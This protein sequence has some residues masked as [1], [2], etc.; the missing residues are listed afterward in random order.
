MIVCVA[1][2]ALVCGQEKTGFEVPS[3]VV[4]ILTVPDS[5]CPLRLTGPFSVIGYPSGGLLLG[6]TIQNRSKANIESFTTEHL[7]W[8]GNRGYTSPA[9][10]REDWLFA[11][12]LQYSTLVN[13]DK[14]RLVAYEP[15]VARDSG[16]ANPSNK[17]WLVMVVKVK[18]SDGTI[19]DTSK[20]FER[21]TKFIDELDL[22]ATMSLEELNNAECKLRQFVSILIASSKREKF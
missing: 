2:V 19:Y 4:T 13:I 3:E 8:F 5:E 6:Y 14:K 7:S 10:V 11:P 22:N 18:L 12:S 20:D 16:I 21:L 1:D 15:K 17:I 9:E